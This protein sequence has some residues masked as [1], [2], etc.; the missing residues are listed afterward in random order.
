MELTRRILL[1]LDLVF[2]IISSLIAIIV[3]SKKKE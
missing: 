1:N 2:I 3:I